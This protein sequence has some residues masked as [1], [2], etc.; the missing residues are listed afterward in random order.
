MHWFNVKGGRACSKKFH[1]L[2]KLFEWVL[3]VRH[4]NNVVTVHV[5]GSDACTS[6]DI[7]SA[8]FPPFGAAVALMVL[9]VVERWN[10]HFLLEVFVQ[11]GREKDSVRGYCAIEYWVPGLD[12]TLLCT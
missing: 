7:E 10:Q 2:W 5:A 8:V 3:E 9:S 11:G 4:W 1:K 12:V 6:H